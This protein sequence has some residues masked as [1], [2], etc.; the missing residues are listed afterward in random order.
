[1][2]H[3]VPIYREADNLSNMVGKNDKTYHHREIYDLVIPK[4][5]LAM[6]P[7]DA[8]KHS[9]EYYLNATRRKPCR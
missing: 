2:L 8:V 9:G 6:L 3:I 7:Y 1:M 5:V 4:I